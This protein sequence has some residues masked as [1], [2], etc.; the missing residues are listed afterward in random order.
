VALVVAAVAVAQAL[1][2]LRAEW[3][4]GVRCQG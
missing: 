2:D 3:P 4:S 1:G